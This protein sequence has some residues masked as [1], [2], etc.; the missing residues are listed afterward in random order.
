MRTLRSSSAEWAR[1]VRA[2]SWSV[3]ESRIGVS[4]G[5]VGSD[6][7]AEWPILSRIVAIPQDGPTEAGRRSR[8]WTA[9]AFG[10]DRKHVADAEE[11]EARLAVEAK[12]RQW[13]GAKVGGERS[14]EI[15]GGKVVATTFK[16]GAEVPRPCGGPCR[17]EPA[18]RMPRRSSRSSAFG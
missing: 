9:S 7:I 15:R 18:P 1:W 13:A 12:E 14:G 16:T 8:S 6:L 3:P 2:S 11:I 17:H 10:T 4:Q 5:H